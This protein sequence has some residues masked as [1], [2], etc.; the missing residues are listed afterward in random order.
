MPS[1][2]TLGEGGRDFE[3][4]NFSKSNKCTCTNRQ[5]H[6]PRSTQTKARML[7]TLCNS[8]INLSTPTFARE[9]GRP[10]MLYN[11]SLRASCGGSA[12]LYACL[13]AARS[14]ASL[15][16]ATILKVPQRLQC[17]HGCPPV[18]ASSGAGIPWRN[19]LPSSLRAPL[20]RRWVIC[21]RFTLR[22]LESIGILNVPHAER[23]N[24]G[25]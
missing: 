13:N 19:I 10:P 15:A 22:A 9:P 25:I 21:K 16:L 5:K 4:P 7:V 20:Y 17:L 1:S 6:T 11:P 18:T 8:P 2:L 23:N 14:N 3:D 12:R 24:N